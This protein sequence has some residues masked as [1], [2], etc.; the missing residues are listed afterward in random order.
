VVLYTD[1]E[2]DTK[3]PRNGHTEEQILEALR[4]ADG[5]EKVSKT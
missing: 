3:M 4:Q 2:D 5:G 1:E